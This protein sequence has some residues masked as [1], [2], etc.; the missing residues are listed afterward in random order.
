MKSSGVDERLREK[1]I[2]GYDHCYDDKENKY[3]AAVPFPFI[4]NQVSWKII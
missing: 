1:K 2:I 3:N 4:P